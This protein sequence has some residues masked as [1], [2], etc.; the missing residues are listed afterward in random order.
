MLWLWNWSSHGHRVHHAAIENQH[1]WSWGHVKLFVLMIPQRQEQAFNKVTLPLHAHLDHKAPKLPA[2]CCTTSLRYIKFISGPT[3]YISKGR[4]N[5]AHWPAFGCELCWKHLQLL[6]MSPQKP[7]PLE[8][9]SVAFSQE[10]TGRADQGGDFSL[11][12]SDS[13]GVAKSP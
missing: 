4:K 3:Q 5:N 7:V 11:P 1:A 6:T 8:N 13:A 9:Q 10:Q 12:S 2:E